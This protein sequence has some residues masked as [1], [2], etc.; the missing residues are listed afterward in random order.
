MKNVPIKNK[1][2]LGALNNFLWYYE[3]KDVVAKNLVLHGRPEGRE[4]F[5]SEKYRDEIIAMDHAHEGYPDSCHAYALKA[6]RLH[7]INQQSD[8]AAEFVERYSKYN[9]EL[10]TLLSTRNNALTQM[11]PPNGYIS[12]HNNANACAY[13][14]IFT[15][16]ETGDGCFKY[17]DGHTGNEVVM[18]DVQGWQ[19]KAGYFGSYHEPWYN[20]VYHAAETDCWRLTVSYMFDRGDMAMNLQDEIIEEIMS[21]Y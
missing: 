6:D 3:N 11:Y 14:L 17:V 12:W 15:W 5:V 18:Q 8:Q 16:S 4:Q 7:H 13:N 10:C 2:I 1:E 21:D 19:C 20:R 9:Q